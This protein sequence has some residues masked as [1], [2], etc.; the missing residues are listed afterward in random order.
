VEKL[1]RAILGGG[2]GIQTDTFSSAED[3]LKSDRVNDTSCLILDVILP[4]LS[5]I[6]LQSATDRAGQ[7]HSDHLHNGCP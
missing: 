1:E 6:E 4:G 7:F 2:I 5:G 3:F